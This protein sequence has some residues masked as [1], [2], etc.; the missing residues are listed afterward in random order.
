MFF[1]FPPYDEDC[2]EKVCFFN[3]LVLQIVKKMT[4][5]IQTKGL[6]PSFM[7]LLK[8]SNCKNIQQ[9]FLKFHFDRVYYNNFVVFGFFRLFITSSLFYI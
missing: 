9:K 5:T 6:D 1:R 3:I 2:I 8:N 4:K 7:I